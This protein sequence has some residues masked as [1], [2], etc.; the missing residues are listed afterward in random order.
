MRILIIAL[1]FIGLISCKNE[2][3]IKQTESVVNEAHSTEPSK[4]IAVN[5]DYHS[6]DYIT[7]KFEPKERRD[8]IL[9]PKQYADR[10][11]M[12]MR[13]DAFDSF[14]EM[15]TAAAKEGI[16]LTIRSAARNFNYQRGIWENKWTGKRLLSDGTNVARDIKDDVEKSLRILEYS[17]MPGSSRHHWGTD[18]DLNSF[19]NKWFETGEG[20]KLYE[21]MK[22]HAADYGYCQ[23]YC[24]KGVHRTDGYNEEKWHY[25]FMP[26]SIELL[27]FAKANLS[28]KDI[29]G[30]KGDHTVEQVGIIKKYI[31]GIDM[32]CHEH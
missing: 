20:L 32:R 18:I 3:T 1:F 4:N 25:S 11:G 22:E 8:F 23:V 2:K 28:Y 29:S 9:I 26:E 24:E 12:Y 14:V 13:K 31:L 16:T 6:I 10:T 15:H 21:W 19:E 30:F 27:N 17:S 5:K 7:G